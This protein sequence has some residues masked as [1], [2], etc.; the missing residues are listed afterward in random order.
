[1]PCAAAVARPCPN[2]AGCAAAAAA[3]GRPLPV[4][5]AC[6]AGSRRV[7]GPGPGAAPPAA[8]RMRASFLGAG[9]ALPASVLAARG[10]RVAATDANACAVAHA[11]RFAACGGGA[12]RRCARRGGM[13]RAAPLDWA[14][15][16][17]VAAAAARDGPFDAVVAADVVYS[18]PHCA[19]LLRAVAALLPAPRPA[20]G[21]PPP[22]AVVALSAGRPSAVECARRAAQ[23]PGL[24]A[25]RVAS[26]P[27]LLLHIRRAAPRAPAAANMRRLQAPKFAGDFIGML[28]PLSL[29]WQGVFGL[30][31]GII[32]A[33]AQQ[34]WRVHIHHH[35]MGDEWAR[36]VAWVASLAAFCLTQSTALGVLTGAGP[37]VLKEHSA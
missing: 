8:A 25:R 27:T 14:D 3:A 31:A 10:C 37:H 32:V 24:T 6:A 7:V 23:F 13:L 9:T 30:S 36:Y 22:V 4:S 18:P 26:A 28:W 1:M 16:G 15:E 17:A 11:A 20:A 2:V 29:S 21:A 34:Q 5:A 33:F 19:A 12:P 35:W